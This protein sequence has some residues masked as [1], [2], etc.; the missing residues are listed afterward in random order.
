MYYDGRN[1]PHYVQ[2]HVEC[3]Q[4]ILNLITLQYHNY[5]YKL[6]GI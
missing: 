6:G 2:F 4:N 1:L 3:V 5:Q